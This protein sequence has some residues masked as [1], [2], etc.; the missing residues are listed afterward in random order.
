M[1][2]SKIESYLTS[3]EIE[4]AH[5]CATRLILSLP[6]KVKMNNN[7]VLLGYGGGKDS[8]YTV[9]WVRYIQHI[10]SR[11][12]NGQTFQLRIVTNRHA[13]MNSQVMENIDRV[14]NALN[15]YGDPSVECLLADDLMIRP[16]QSTLPLPDS[17]LR[18]NRTDV[19][20]NGHKFRADAR[21][22]FCNACNLSM[23]NSFSC[24]S[25]F[26]GGVDIIITGDSP[27]E[28][29]AYFAWVRQLSRLFKNPL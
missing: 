1:N 9:A 2:I 15:I 6:N 25:H 21:S 3:A 27:K 10:V 20:M 22:T 23:V 19:L 16:F 5:R 11:R 8:S 17:V 14:Y 12:M 28:Q 18:R 24:A 7:R 13:G 4:S 26:N 29:L